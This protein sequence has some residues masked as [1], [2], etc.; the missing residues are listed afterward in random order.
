MAGEGEDAQDDINKGVSAGT[1]EE[2]ASVSTKAEDVPG[3]EEEDT[4]AD[5]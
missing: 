4:L 3:D 1:K 5:I 2:D